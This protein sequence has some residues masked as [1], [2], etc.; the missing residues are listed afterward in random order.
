MPDSDKIHRLYIAHLTLPSVPST[1]PPTY[2]KLDDV[3]VT[4]FESEHNAKMGDFEVPYA[5]KGSAPIKFDPP[6][7][8]ELKVL[9]EQIRPGSLSRNEIHKN[10]NPVEG[11]EFLVEGARVWVGKKAWV[12]RDWDRGPKRWS[13]DDYELD[14]V[15]KAVPEGKEVA[16][17]WVEGIGVGYF[18]GFFSLI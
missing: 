12:T 8:L 3:K 1:K 16:E 10:D 18:G 15:E 2:P 17:R 5:P 11:G 4:L 7:E 13:E 6:S 9:L 14:K